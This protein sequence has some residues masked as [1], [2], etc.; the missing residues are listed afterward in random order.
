ML[1]EQMR[2]TFTILAVTTVACVCF[3]QVSSDKPLQFIGTDAERAVIGVD[4]PIS[5]SSAV[6]VNA[7]VATGG[8]TW[9]TATLNA[10]T[11]VLTTTP[12]VSTFTNGTLLRF[13]SPAD[14]YNELYVELVV[15]S[16]AVPLLRPDGL[17][18]TK[19]QIVSG[20]VCEVLYA[21]GRMIL[22]NAP[23]VGCPPGFLSVTDRLCIEQNV[24][25]DMLFHPARDRCANLGGKICTWADFVVGCTNL[26]DQLQALFT[27]WEWM[28]DTSNHS[29]GSDMVGRLTCGSQRNV[30]LLTTFTANS[31]CCYHPR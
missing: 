9:S 30:G 12:A 18:P 31:L 24:V 11:L 14:L 2:T 21:D 4:F 29:H 10:N 1:Y 3:A 26:N 28:D 23:E 22:L 27:D 5:G 17:S 8:F 6:T 15:G 25:P 16:P 19:G 20:G 13:V 7:S